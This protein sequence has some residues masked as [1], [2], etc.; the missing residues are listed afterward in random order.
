MLKK[1]F[2]NPGMKISLIS[3]LVNLGLSLGK[4]AAGIFGH[5][6]AMIAD[7]VHSASDVFSTIIVIGAL[8]L[9]EKEADEGHQYGHEKFESLASLLLAAVLALTGF[10]IG[11]TAVR[12]LIKGTTSAV[13][14][15]G[16]ALAAAVI[17]IAVK[18]VMY[19]VTV[20]IGKRQQSEAL[21]ADAW[22]HRSDALSSI[23]SFVGILF[24]MLGFPFMD[25]VAG[26]VICVFIIKT[27]WDIAKPSL[28]KLTDESCDKETEAKFRETV[29]SVDNVIRLDVLR[30]RRF[31][32]GYYVDLE[33]AVDGSMPTQQ[34]HDIAESVHDLL[35]QTYPDIRHCMVHVNP[36]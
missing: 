12:S 36:A 3:I 35:E 2:N 20:R 19:Q 7:A 34:A 24:A 25:A 16:I 17:S 29:L 23:G 5:S 31:G 33:I 9:S 15:S 4:L 6:Q 32:N 28:S 26:L 8:M 10:G 30:T 27:A 13:L 11:K 22:H 14:P 21:I 1:L 18:E